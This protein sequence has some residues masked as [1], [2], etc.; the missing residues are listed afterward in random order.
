MAQRWGKYAPP[1]PR[2]RHNP[3]GK[4]QPLKIRYSLYMDADTLADLRLRH[5]ETFAAHRMPFP[6]W[7]ERKLARWSKKRAIKA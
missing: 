4:E 2:P 3:T 7:L 6:A 1:S 5:A